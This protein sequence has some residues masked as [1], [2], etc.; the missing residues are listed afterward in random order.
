[1]KKISNKKLKEKIKKIIK[2]TQPLCQ[3]SRKIRPKKCR[4]ERQPTCKSL[5]L[6]PMRTVGQASQDGVQVLMSHNLGVSEGRFGSGSAIELLR[7]YS[8]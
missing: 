5:G 1:M 4:T 8:I 6:W 2:G 7:G 3:G